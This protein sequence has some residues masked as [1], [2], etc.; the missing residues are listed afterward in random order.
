[1]D[2]TTRKTLTIYGAL[3][4]KSDN[5]RLYLK[6]K[7]RG[8]GLISIEM[9]VTL[10]ENILDLYVCGSNEMLLK[11]IKKVSI[12]KTENLMEKEDF[13]KNSQNEFKNKWHE[14]KMYGQFVREML[15]EIEDVPWKWLV[16]SDLKV[17]NE[18]TI[19]AAQEQVLRTNYTNNKNEKNSRHGKIHFM[20]CV[21]K[22]EKLC[23]I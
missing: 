14:K 4:P 10:E 23:S 13:K 17:Q 15:K 12:V 8:K 7:H 1:M 18:A 11:S 20:E 22:G 19:C 3:H 5:D 6:R 9:C 21:V 16:Q 2:R